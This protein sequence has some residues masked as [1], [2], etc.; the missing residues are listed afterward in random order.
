MSTLTTTKFALA[1]AVSL[2]CMPT[3][4]A[5]AAGVAWVYEN[6]RHACK[7]R[8]VSDE[9][10]QLIKC[11]TM[12]FGSLRFPNR[13]PLMDA[14]E[15]FKGNRRMGVFGCLN[16]FLGNT[17]VDVG[18]EPSLS[19]TD[20]P[21]FSL[22]RFRFLSLQFTPLSEISGSGFFYVRISKHLSVAGYSNLVHTQIYADNVFRVDGCIFR[23]ITSGVEEKLAI[24]IDQINLTRNS[25]GPPVVVISNGDIERASSFQR[26]QR[27]L[28]IR[29][30]HSLECQ[31]ALVI[32]NRPSFLEL[33]LDFFVDFVCVTSLG[34]SS[35]GEL[36]RQSIFLSDLAVNQ[37]LDGEL[38][39]GVFDEAG[40]GNL[41]AGSVEG[42]HSAE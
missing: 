5:H 13:C 24:A 38:R 31:D 4:P 25:V 2:F 33:G 18:S 29:K 34:D 22:A 9:H 20:I 23:H 32:G 6:D 16:E 8:F 26:G 12:F 3:H 35:D 30:A 1:L 39:S 14:G 10:S 36:R 19:T 37:F 42:F 41:I 21:Q 7:H 11:P 40:L 27:Y 17:V 15:V 28:G